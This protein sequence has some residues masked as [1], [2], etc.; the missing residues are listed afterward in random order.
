MADDGSGATLNASTLKAAAWNAT[1]TTA[2]L[3]FDQR[4]VVVVGANTHRL[5]KAVQE[6]QAPLVAAC[7]MERGTDG[8]GLGELGY[9]IDSVRLLSPTDYRFDKTGAFVAE[10]Q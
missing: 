10:E 8:V 5:C 3:E 1:A 7:M 9:E 4:L 6:R 2:V